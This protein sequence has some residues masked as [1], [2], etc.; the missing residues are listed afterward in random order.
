MILIIVAVTHL[1]RCLLFKKL[2]FFIQTIYIVLFTEELLLL[3]VVLPFSSNNNGSTSSSTSSSL[4]SSINFYFI[5]TNSTFIAVISG[6]ASSQTESQFI[7]L[8]LLAITL[9]TSSLVKK[10]IK[11]ILPEIQL[12]VIPFFIYVTIVDRS[13][14]Y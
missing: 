11:I 12:C 14:I 4:E 13:T 7:S 6:I 1:L 8:W 9:I 2:L 10:K 5:C 3:V